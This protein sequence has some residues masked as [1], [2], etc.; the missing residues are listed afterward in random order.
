MLRHSIPGSK[1]LVCFTPSLAQIK[2]LCTAR[3]LHLNTFTQHPCG[4]RQPNLNWKHPPG[5]PWYS[6][7][8]VYK[9]IQ[10]W[11]ER[12]CPSCLGRGRMAQ[13]RSKDPLQASAWQKKDSIGQQ[14]GRDGVEIGD[15]IS[16]HARKRTQPSVSLVQCTPDTQSQRGFGRSRSACIW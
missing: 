7:L 16:A 13:R 1:I 11:P 6:Q 14:K 5:F 8:S 12:G 4:D 2:W 15:S 10:T 3:A 9:E